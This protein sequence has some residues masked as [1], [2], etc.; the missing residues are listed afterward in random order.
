MINPLI[1]IYSV[2]LKFKDGISMGTD[3][4][5]FFLE[6]DIEL[7]KADPNVAEITIT[8]RTE[9]LFYSWKTP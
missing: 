2:H 5:P 7:Y 6:R 3:L 8:E 4:D 9:R 1:V